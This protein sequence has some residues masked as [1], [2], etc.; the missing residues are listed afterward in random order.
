MYIWYISNTV[1]FRQ[2]A[3]LFGVAKSSAW[4]SVGE[5]TAWLV[6]IGHE[7]LRWPRGSFVEETCKKFED[8]KKIPRVI[9]AIDC[10]HIS[11]NA[12]KVAKE[13]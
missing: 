1:T 2:L 9:G 12:P 5:V 10:T 6:S 13:C 8:K 4:K 7:F 3:N 11:I